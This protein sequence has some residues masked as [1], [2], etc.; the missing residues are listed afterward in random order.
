[1]DVATLAMNSADFFE[2]DAFLASSVPG[3]VK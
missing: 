1:M 3:S 2:R